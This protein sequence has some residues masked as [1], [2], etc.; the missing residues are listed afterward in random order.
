MTHISRFN[1][2]ASHLKRDC[3]RETLKTNTCI[4]I[5]CPFPHLNKSHQARREARKKSSREQFVKC[6]LSLIHE[7]QMLVQRCRQWQRWHIQSNWMRALVKTGIR[8]W[9]LGSAVLVPYELLFCGSWTASKLWGAVDGKYGMQIHPS[10]GARTRYCPFLGQT[11]F[12]RINS[13][14][15]LDWESTYLSPSS[16][17]HVASGHWPPQAHWN[18]AIFLVKDGHNGNSWCNKRVQKYGI[19]VEYQ[20]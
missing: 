20:K 1:E 12:F 17:P 18:F 11:W 7:T 6:I 14:F 3:S 19:L 2:S 4:R 10:S 13:R 15:P 16:A 8:E 9:E 5:C